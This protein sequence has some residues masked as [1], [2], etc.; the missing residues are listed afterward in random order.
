MNT[1]ENQ[2]YIGNWPS[3]EKYGYDRMLPVDKIKFD[4]W[5][6]TVQDQPFYFENE[7]ENY[8]LNDVEILMFSVMSFRKLFKDIT[9][10]DPFTRNFTLASIGLEVYRSKFL[11]EK[12][13]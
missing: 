3:K 13:P 10:L 5:Y 9:E 1:I 4:E 11:K 7:I 6:V 12:N 2:H 8:C